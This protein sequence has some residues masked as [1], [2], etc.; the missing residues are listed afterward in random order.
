MSDTKINVS[1][2][3][4]AAGSKGDSRGSPSELPLSGSLHGVPV[5]QSVRCDCLS[6]CSAG[7]RHQFVGD[8]HICPVVCPVHGSNTL[9]RCASSG[10]GPDLAR[11][12]AIPRDVVGVEAYKDI[13]IADLTAKSASGPSSIAF[14]SVDLDRI[15]RDKAQRH[16]D[17]MSVSEEDE[18]ELLEVARV[19]PVWYAVF[20]FGFLWTGLSWLFC[21]PL[22]FIGVAGL[23]RLYR[24]L[25]LSHNRVAIAVARVCLKIGD[26]VDCVMVRRAKKAVGRWVDRH[27]E[28]LVIGGILALTAMAVYY[29]LKWSRSRE[30]QELQAKGS[31]DSVYRMPM[32]VLSYATEALIV[33]I[34][35]CS[36]GVDRGAKWGRD[37]CYAVRA[38][39]TGL[40]WLSGERGEEQRPQAGPG[41][42]PSPALGESRPPTPGSPQLDVSRLENDAKAPAEAA[43]ACPSLS[44]PPFFSSLRKKSTLII[45]RAMFKSEQEFRTALKFVLTDEGEYV[46]GFHPELGTV[47]DALAGNTSDFV[48]FFIAQ[49]NLEEL[50]IRPWQSLVFTREQVAGYCA[51]LKAWCLKGDFFTERPALIIAKSDMRSWL[52]SYCPECSDVY[53]ALNKFCKTTK[54]VIQ[55]NGLLIVSIVCLAAI[56]VTLYHVSRTKSE[57]ALY[58]RK[59][60]N[61][62]A[63]L[64]YEVQATIWKPGQAEEVQTVTA[65]Y[66]VPV[67]VVKEEAV[68]A[69]IERINDL[70]PK[71]DE[72]A[73]AAADEKDVVLEARKHKPK[74]DGS[75]NGSPNGDQPDEFDV[76]D[77]GRA[78]RRREEREAEYNQRL[79]EMA[80]HYGQFQSPENSDTEAKAVGVVQRLPLGGISQIVPTKVEAVAKKPAANAGKPAADTVVEA[81]ES[82]KILMPSYAAIVK[83]DPV[84]KFHIAQRA[85]KNFTDLAKA[86]QRA[87]IDSPQN[88]PRID[89]CHKCMTGCRS[90]LKQDGSKHNCATDDDIKSLLARVSMSPNCPPVVEKYWKYYKTR[91]ICQCEAG[92]EKCLDYDTSTIEGNNASWR[93]AANEY[94][95]T[96][97]ELKV[98]KVRDLPIDKSTLDKL[99]KNRKPEDP[100]IY[101]VLVDS[102][103]RQ[104]AIPITW[105]VENNQESLN[106]NCYTFD[107]TE[108]TIN[109]MFLLEVEGCKVVDGVEIPI[110]GQLCNGVCVGGYYLTVA[111]LWSKEFD[112]RIRHKSVTIS[113][114][115]MG[116][117]TMTTRVTDASLLREFDMYFDAQRLNPENQLADLFVIPQG[118]WQKANCPRVKSSSFHSNQ[119]FLKRITVLTSLD[120][121]SENVIIRFSPLFMVEEEVSQRMGEKTFTRLRYLASTQ[122]GQSGAGIFYDGA[123]VGYHIAGGRNPGVQT[124]R[125]FDA[126]T[127]NL[128]A[129]CNSPQTLFTA[130]PALPDELK[131][132]PKVYNPATAGQ[133]IQCKVAPHSSKV[134]CGSEFI[135]TQLK[136]LKISTED[137]KF[138]DT[139][140]DKVHKGMSGFQATPALSYDESIMVDFVDPCMDHWFGGVALKEADF[141]LDHAVDHAPKTGANGY[142]E[143]QFF[144]RKKELLDKLAVRL[145]SII[146]SD[147]IEFVGRDDNGRFWTVQQIIR[148]IGKGEVV[149]R[150][151]YENDDQR[152]VWPTGILHFVVGRYLYEKMHKKFAFAR[153]GKTPYYKGRSRYYGEHNDLVHRMLDWSMTADLKKWDQH[154][155]LHLTERWYRFKEKFLKPLGDK[156]RKLHW[157]FHDQMTQSWLVN[158]VGDIIIR[159]FGLPSGCVTTSD[160]G[161][162]E[163]IMMMVYILAWNMKKWGWEHDRILDAIIGPTPLFV[164]VNCSDDNWTS[165]TQQWLLAQMDFHTPAAQH[166]SIIKTTMI[167]CTRPPLYQRGSIP[168]L[169]DLTYNGGVL[170]FLPV[171]EKIGKAYAQMEMHTSVGDKHM[172]LQLLRVYTFRVLGFWDDDFRRNCEYIIDRMLET[173][174]PQNDRMVLP[175]GSSITFDTT[176]SVPMSFRDICQ[177][178]T[179]LDSGEIKMHAT[180]KENQRI[181]FCEPAIN[182]QIF[183]SATMGKASKKKNKMKK[184]ARALIAAKKAASVGRRVVKGPGAF[185]DVVKGVGNFAGN[186]ARGIGAFF[187]SGKYYSDKG[188]K[189]GANVRRGDGQ[190][191]IHVRH[192]AAGVQPPQ[193]SNTREG[194]RITHVEFIGNVVVPADS[195]GKFIN[196]VYPIQPGSQRTFP[197][198]STQAQAWTK[199]DMKKCMFFFESNASNVN[200]ATDAGIGLGTVVLATKYLVT[201]EPFKDMNA[202]NSN[203]AT[204]SKPSESF[205]HGIECDPAYK[206]YKQYFIDKFES[207]ANA[208]EKPKKEQSDMAN[209]NVIVEGIPDAPVDQVIGKLFVSYDI[210]LQSQVLS[211]AQNFWWWYATD[212]DGD[213]PFG[214]AANRTL[215]HG[216]NT[217]LEWTFGPGTATSGAII[218]PPGVAGKFLFVWSSNRGNVYGSAPNV[219]P[220]A[221]YV[222][223][224]CFGDLTSPDSGQNV[225]DTVTAFMDHIFCFEIQPG[226]WGDLA[227]TLTFA[228]GFNTGDAAS[229]T[230]M[231]V[232]LPNSFDT[233]LPEAAMSSR[234][235]SV[236]RE[237]H[238]YEEK[239]NELL[240]RVDAA[241]IPKLQKKSIDEKEDKKEKPLSVEEPP[242]PEPGTVVVEPANKVVLPIGPIGRVMAAAA[243]WPRS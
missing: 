42:A 220:T 43:E 68:S 202:L 196:K 60:S 81:K 199:Y 234:V 166:G 11:F 8:S 17:E 193:V 169:G 150:E 233:T 19:S 237:L 128:I 235:K 9:L 77:I 145:K 27:K 70:V 135:S 171:P 213:N 4:A 120:R 105:K 63:P 201:E 183:Q 86:V 122:D 88:Q 98:G 118:W 99:M 138:M 124:G 173:G 157:W 87:L 106:E 78:S 39:V 188:W 36:L 191:A 103:N 197:W 107:T 181:V 49:Y 112:G 108:A 221:A 192:I 110:Q 131:V 225:G 95:R 147:T 160:D 170:G 41:E 75:R 139:T 97:R 172:A 127:K 116:E 66:D 22:S 125:K 5:V 214:T 94:R 102:Q 158:L 129:W 54:G 33:V 217:E 208:A 6:A 151:K 204:S 89:F 126:N 219:T 51:K 15:A 20:L 56:S 176:R 46:I 238:L 10:V 79:D 224:K 7:D 117:S 146:R 205:L 180:A 69:D 222:E 162:G 29:L 121:V 144:N 232:Q 72:T 210:E 230:L 35:I 25:S 165:A 168:F 223:E 164:F 141:D 207:V 182:E 130:N 65:H 101:E 209:L 153:N 203:Y 34:S 240:K 90:T 47:C 55:E 50:G 136:K 48:E 140:I 163:A 96:R 59:K 84:E 115:P 167:A 104:V 83:G 206:P 2:E 239:Y 212:A 195:A 18:P 241:G 198:L 228:S 31:G 80:E 190:G 194:V 229:M 61:L 211:S 73:K 155:F 111:H 133:T 189:D 137:W 109:S 16:L 92:K 200:N 91:T 243:K 132:T 1:V 71:R 24:R 231:I 156:G 185:S 215:M 23:D 218:A 159:K 45:N 40:S 216:S 13:T 149:T 53:G 236:Q 175:D 226:E 44:R 85:N 58:K 52:L 93:R 74:W 177:L 67:K 82:K 114:K 32:T 113:T 123:C 178:Y 187:G 14:S 3:S 227:R 28:N 21:I 12:I 100:V 57:R 143:N 26:V 38:V 186:L 62:D 134:D 119:P 142:P 154:Q 76:R 152:V 148:V 64:P 37:I 179:G 161:T 184:A 174:L 242:S 30:K